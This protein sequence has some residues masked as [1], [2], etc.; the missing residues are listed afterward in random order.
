MEMKLE[1]FLD[2]DHWFATKNDLEMLL[3]TEALKR[4]LKK[5]EIPVET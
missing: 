4:Y 3:G 5:E 2:A 1:L